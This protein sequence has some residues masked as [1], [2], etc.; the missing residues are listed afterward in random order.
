MNQCVKYEYILG[1]S[2]LSGKCCDQ[3]LN[4][5]HRNINQD[6]VY[7]ILMNIPIF[8]IYKTPEQINK[9]RSNIVNYNYTWFCLLY[10]NYNFSIEIIKKLLKDYIDYYYVDIININRLIN[11]P[12]DAFIIMN[13]FMVV[14]QNYIRNYYE[15]RS[16]CIPHVSAYQIAT[17]NYGTRNIY[18]LI[19][20]EYNDLE[21]LKKAI[22]LSS[23]QMNFLKI[24]RYCYP[25]IEM[26]K[27]YK[28]NIFNNALNNTFININDFQIS[29]NCE[30]IINQ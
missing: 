19:C 13:E 6:D 22:F 17:V 9:I 23:E 7:E 25:S 10:F 26:F 24:S 2:K 12:E 4:L 20:Y 15:L 14:N 29:E 5:Y 3:F 1:L 18:E 16:L 30:F 11:N 28:Y 21:F 8:H 27:K